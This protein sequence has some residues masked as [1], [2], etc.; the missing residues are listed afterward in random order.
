[1]IDEPVGNKRTFNYATG[2]WV[3]APVVGRVVAQ[4][5]PLLGITPDM[6][7]EEP[8]NLPLIDDEVKR[9]PKIAANT[10]LVK[11]A[12]VSS[13]VI[14]PA[15]TLKPAV[16]IPVEAPPPP[17]PRM[18]TKPPPEARAPS[19]EVPGETPDERIARKTREALEQ[20]FA[21]Q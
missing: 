17:L 14:R 7:G 15:G 9:I 12:S 2:G 3:A 11:K 6:T 20:A 18:K 8:L 19:T 1:M 10:D 5:G 13:G 16:T 4:I 21:A